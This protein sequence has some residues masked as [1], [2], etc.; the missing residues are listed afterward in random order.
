MAF[1]GELRCWRRAIRGVI[2]VL[3]AKAYEGERFYRVGVFYLVAPY[4]PL[5]FPSA[6]C[7]SCLSAEGLYQPRPDRS[8]PVV[9]HSV[10]T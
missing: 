1:V 10:I 8:T 4:Q 6:G 5:F 9:F 3:A 2:E 7:Q